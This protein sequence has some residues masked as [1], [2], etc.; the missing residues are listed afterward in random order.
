MFIAIT[1]HPCPNFYTVELYQYGIKTHTVVTSE[2][3]R[4]MEELFKDC[5]GGL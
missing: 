1:T 3:G 2:I 5:V 4:T